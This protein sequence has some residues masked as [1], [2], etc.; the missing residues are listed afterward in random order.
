MIV[1]M[2]SIYVRVTNTINT[3][4]VGGVESV[5]SAIFNP[6][7]FVGQSYCISLGMYVYPYSYK[8][9]VVHKKSYEYLTFLLAMT[10]IDDGFN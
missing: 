1:N 7:F 3:V 6:V 10:L 2:L 4:I 5:D 8:R 9:F